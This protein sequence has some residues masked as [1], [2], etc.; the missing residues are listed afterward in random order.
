MPDGELSDGDHLQEENGDDDD[1]DGLA[2]V[3]K[4]DHEAEYIDEDRYTT[5]V[6]EAIDLS[7]EGLLKAEQE[8]QDASASTEDAQRDAAAKPS[9]QKQGK[10]VWHK[11]KPK[12][13]GQVVKRKRKKFRYESKP[14]RKVSRLK[15]KSKN[16]KQAKARR[17]S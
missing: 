5:V 10:R 16:S 7:R 15:Q 13:D 12:K 4:I 17:A 8:R 1:W 2:E 14:E 9:N 11:E 3:P 6:V